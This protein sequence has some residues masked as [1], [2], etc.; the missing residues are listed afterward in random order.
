MPHLQG[1]DVGAHR[2][3]QFV[4]SPLF[5]MPLRVGVYFFTVT[6]IGTAPSL[7]ALGMGLYG[8]KAAVV[9]MLERSWRQSSQ[10][11]NV[12]VQFVE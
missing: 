6:Q 7:V 10:D 8:A 9:A 11:Y 5:E 12:H 4:V 2:E 3:A 1:R